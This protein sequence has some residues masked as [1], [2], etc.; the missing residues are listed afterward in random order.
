MIDVLIATIMVMFAT[1]S[2]LDAWFEGSVFALPRAYTEAWKGSNNS[3]IRLSGE[4]FTCRFCLGYHVAFI[5]SLICSFFVTDWLI[6]FLIMFAARGM[7]Y[8]LNK[9]T[10]YKY[11]TKE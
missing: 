10:E 2:F 4:L 11:D 6:I 7:E 8:E 3:V 5:F 9:F 1:K